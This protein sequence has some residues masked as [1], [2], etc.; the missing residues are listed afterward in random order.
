M[1]DDFAAVAAAAAV[2]RRVGAAAAGR[3]RRLR[4]A[5][6][7][8]RLE[9]DGGGLGCLRRAREA[10]EATHTRRKRPSRSAATAAAT[11]TRTTSVEGVTRPC[12]VTFQTRDTQHRSLLLRCKTSMSS[13]E[14]SR[15]EIRVCV[16]GAT[17]RRMQR[18][19]LTPERDLCSPYIHAFSSPFSAAAADTGTRE[20]SSCPVAFACRRRRRRCRRRCR[21][22][23]H[24]A[25]LA[26]K[27]RTAVSC[28][29]YRARTLLPRTLARSLAPPPLLRRA[30]E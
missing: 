24:F 28:E 27:T 3:R 30:T 9:Q 18:G 14:M 29:G 23:R 1:D 5:Q 15:G 4:R 13:S 25:K 11:P 6:P 10:G 20:H 7:L 16:R 8:D 26:S 22:R 12:E 19:R 2:G 17:S 21:R